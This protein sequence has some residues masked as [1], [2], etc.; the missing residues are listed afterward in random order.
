VFG[1]WPACDP[2]RLNQLLDEA[3]F[4]R[5]SDYADQGITDDIPF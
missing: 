3:S 1:R 4:R 5:E 2:G